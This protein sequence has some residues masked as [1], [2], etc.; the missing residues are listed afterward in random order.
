MEIGVSIERALE[1]SSSFPLNYE[2]ETISIIDAHNRIL[3][4]PLTSNVDDPLFDNSA[5]DGWAVIESDCLS[6]PIKLSIIGTSQAGETPDFIVTKGTA[7]RIMTGAPIPSGADSIVLIEDSEIIDN[8]VLING[9]ARPNYIRK[10]GENLTKNEIC[11]NSGV[12]LKPSQLA[13]ASMMGYSQISVISPPKIAIIG[14]GDELVE[15]GENLKP[16]QIYESN[17]KALFGLIKEMG[18]TPVTYP[19]VSDDLNKLREI[20][21]IASEECDAI[22]TSGGV[23]MGERDIVRKL[24]ENE[25]EIKYWKI[26][27]KPGGPPIFGLWNN[28]PFFG[29]PGNPVSSQIV[30]MTVVVPWIS[31][32]CGYD[33]F[34][35][36]KLFEKVRVKLLSNAKGT[37][38]KVT[39]RRINIFFDDDILVASVPNNQGSGNLRGMVDCNGLTILPIGVDGKKDD[40]IDAIWIR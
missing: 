2:I 26:K 33:N 23:S 40:F 19:F 11:L 30:F 17:T 5:M 15:P 22:I 31:N 8:K 25:G 18:C 20:L 37:N 28:T 36:P 24:M 29:L 13:I 4:T 35:G 32:S 12:L 16:G 14:T 10:R 38:N 3:S 6:L 27:I 1:I 21:N 39:Y 9:P 7:S 34:D